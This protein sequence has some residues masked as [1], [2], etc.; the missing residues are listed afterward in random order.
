MIS[1]WITRDHH[2]TLRLSNIGASERIIE[3]TERISVSEIDRVQIT[4]DEKKTSG[5]K[6]PDADGFIKWQLKLKPHGREKLE[7]F[8]TIKKKSDVQASEL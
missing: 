8:Y 1:T 5:Q 7:L 4:V 3:L 2:V 6:K